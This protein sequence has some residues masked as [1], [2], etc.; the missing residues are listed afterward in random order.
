M[1]ITFHVFR[2]ILTNAGKCVPNADAGDRLIQSAIYILGMTAQ[3]PAEFLLL[4][5]LRRAG[6]KQPAYQA[7]CEAPVVESTIAYVAL[8]PGALRCRFQ[9][10][11]HLCRLSD[12]LGFGFCDAVLEVARCGLRWLGG[13]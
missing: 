11:A 9:V 1:L 7:A 6:S 12:L 10:A 4:S 5:A 8:N 2:V 13:C 3:R